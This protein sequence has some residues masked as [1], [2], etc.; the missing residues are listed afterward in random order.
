[1]LSLDFIEHESEFYGVYYLSKKNNGETYKLYLNYFDNEY[2][3][4]DYKEFPVLL[5]IDKVSTTNSLLDLIREN[6]VDA[7]PIS[8]RE[9]NEVEAKAFK[10]DNLNPVLIKTRKLT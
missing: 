8:R 4:E 5:G 7:I 9:I 1:M 2:H 3:E 6:I 10:F